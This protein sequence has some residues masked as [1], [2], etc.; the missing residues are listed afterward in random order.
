MA[1]KINKLI[2]GSIN[3]I[4]GGS[5]PAS[6]E[7]TWIWFDGQENYEEFDWSG[8]ITNSMV[9]DAKNS[10]KIIKVEIG[11]NVTSIGSNALSY[12]INLTSV[13]IPDSVTSIG[14]SAFE[15]CGNLTSITIP[16]S[17]TSIGDF[18][19]YDCYSLTSAS[20]LGFTQ[21]QIR[22]NTDWCLNGGMTITASDGTFTL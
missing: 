4:T 17:V 9:S 13:T 20:I 3:I 2:G 5:E 16:D 7:K 22:A 1:I 8:E 12:C 18:A 19:F 14:S 21:T 6:H 15:C 10:R 11:T